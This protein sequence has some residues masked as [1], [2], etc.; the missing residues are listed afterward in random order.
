MNNN[1]IIIII[2]IIGFS[3]IKSNCTHFRHL[4]DEQL[5]LI[6]FEKLPVQRLELITCMF[7]LALNAESVNVI[8]SNVFYHF[9]FSGNLSSKTKWICIC[10]RWRLYRKRNL[11]WRTSHVKGE[12]SVLVFVITHTFWSMNWLFSFCFSLIGFKLEFITYYNQ[13]LVK[14]LFT[15]LLLS[16]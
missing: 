11:R 7:T 1:N 15:A 5:Q 9:I 4:T 2:I 12:P 6:D 3:S 10:D 13:L 16:K 14:Y 8:V